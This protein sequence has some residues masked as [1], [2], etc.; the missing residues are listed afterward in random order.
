MNEPFKQNDESYLQLDKWMRLEPKLV[1]GFTTRVGGISE[2]P[3]DTLNFGLHTKDAQNSIVA[4]REILA[5]KLRVPLQRW[6][7]GEQ[8][9][10]V[11]VVEIT[12]KEIGKGSVSYDSSIKDVDGLFTISKNVLC[13]AFFADCV[14][15]FFFDPVSRYIGIAHAGWRG[16]VGRI[17]ENMIHK[18]KAKGVN[19]DTLQVAIGPCISGGEYEVDENVIKNLTEVEK[20]IA[21]KKSD[22][23][24][25]LLDL[26]LLN[27]EI[28]LQNGVSIRN[29]EVTQFCTKAHQE[30]FFSYR[31]DEGKTG[32]MLGFIGF[33]E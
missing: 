1:A 25:Y 5:N 26:R 9:H 13:T 14:P 15:L 20:A 18:L 2:T 11:N 10:G 8:T 28:F 21:V 27:K 4:N 3:Y 29:I 6:V 31:R 16:T 33:R 32:R 24:R 17:G 19:I 30:L 7:S 23:G 12:D 22:E